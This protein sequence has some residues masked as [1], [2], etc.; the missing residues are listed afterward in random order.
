MRASLNWLSE[1]V[2][3]P[4][5]P[6]EALAERLTVAGLEVERIEPLV[7]EGAIVARVASVE[8]HPRA[9]GLTVC[10]VETGRDARTVVCGADNVRAGGLFP[11]AL[12][13][14]RLPEGGLSVATI[15]G[16]KSEGM[17]LSRK[18][19]GLEARSA[20]IW[21]LPSGLPVGADLA[22]LI[23]FPDTVLSLKITSNRPDLLGIVGIAREISAL[24]RTGFREPELGFP[25]TGPDAATLTSVEIEDPRDCPRYVARVIRGVESPP[26]PLPIQARLLKCGMRPLSLVV[27]ITNYVLLELGHP[28]HA[29]DLRKLAEERIVVRRARS[30]ERLR[31]LDGVERE[32]TP[33]VLVIADAERPAAV[34]G[35]MGGAETEVGAG[36]RAVLL[37]AAAF[38]P[39]RVRRGSRALGLRTEASLRFERGLSPEMADTASRR[40]CALLAQH[41]PAEIARGAVD[42]YPTPARAP[43]VALRRRRIAEVLGVEVPPPEVAAGLARLGLSVRDR[44]ESWEVRIPPFRQDLG[45]EIDLIE[46]VARLYGYD[47]IPAVAPTTEPRIGA[48]DPGE[49]FADRVREI[50]ASLGLVESYALG[51]ASAGETE[52]KLRNPLSQGWD[53]LRP[54]LLPGL[55]A[56][57]RGNLEAQAPGVAAFEV[58]RVFFLQD[59]ALRE[60]DHVGI[61]LAGRSPQPLSGKRDYG[62]ADLKGILDALL[63][64]LRVKGVTLGEIA[65]ARLHPYR[66]AGVYL[67]AHEPLAAVRP[68]LSVDREPWT[69]DGSRA[70]DHRSRTPIGWLGEL[71]PSLTADLP[72]EKRVLALE[73]SLPAL[74]AAARP[75]EHHA[76]PRSPASKRDLSLLVLKGVP[77]GSVRAAILAEP[78]VE[79]V[80]LYDLYRGEG[81][82]ADHV[83]LTYEVA[84]RDPER[85]LASDEV[86]GAV[87][88][89]LARLGALGAR[90]RT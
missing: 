55:L 26:S 51:F 12:P 5:V 42:V 70:T 31:T 33:E 63:G 40:C 38:S 49:A 6:L 9:E 16:V 73:L 3:L 84:F 44:G 85:T 61:V 69:A 22:P 21:D 7:A 11:L 41:A 2:D 77:E 82:P 54:S 36:T 13:G 23:G 59:G 46:E 62:P 29:F 18:E 35:V 14:A 90:I 4:E 65:D 25:E 1:Y 47:R 78:L 48:K 89:I 20:G 56:T 86:E 87:E 34:A 53:G 32:L 28:L 79:S 24:Y 75:A 57:V 19:L 45:R 76:I 71:S 64:A 80:F 50:L 37:E 60:E 81:L 88:R 15:R 43:T 58:G 27:D 30:G 74:R 8:P 17:L 67:A 39:T 72:G 52:V 66:R 83:S 68:P 10:Q